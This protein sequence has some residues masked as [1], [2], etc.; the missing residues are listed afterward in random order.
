MKKDK[1]L[2][3]LSFTILIIAVILLMIFKNSMIKEI[4][5]ISISATLYGIINII[6]DNRIGYIIFSLGICLL[7][8]SILY[9]NKILEK[10]DVFTFMISSS[11]ILISI[12]TLIFNYINKKNIDKKYDLI[13]E[14][15]VEDLVRNN[16]TKKEYYQPI[17]S[18]IIDDIKYNVDFPGFINRNIPSIGSKINLK[19]DSKDYQNVYFEKPLLNRILDIVIMVLLIII[20]IIVLI[21]VFK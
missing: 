18:Y 17:Y 11:V 3:Y 15:T 1:I 7:I 14:A 12:I 9:I 21:D 10:V 8:S 4:F 13:V 16:N 5:I 6:K 19:V 20:A 2:E